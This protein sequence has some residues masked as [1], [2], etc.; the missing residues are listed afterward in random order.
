ML[1]N[2]VARRYAWPLVAVAQEH[3]LTEA[4]GRDLD[5]VLATLGADQRLS[6]IL[7]HPAV[8]AS[9]KKELLR[10]LFSGR[11]HPYA[12][13]FLFLLQD[14]KR[15][16]LLPVIVAE[17]H[18]EAN[19]ALGIL[20]VRVESARPLTPAQRDRLRS[21]LAKALQ[22]Q[23]SLEAQVRPELIGGLRIQVEDRVLDGS[24][25][26]QLE[27]LRQQITRTAPGA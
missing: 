8:Q 27:R 7:A 12:L 2:P 13:N 21:R 16:H 19:R 10:Q 18:R 15:G 26:Y 11:V 23:V 24:L 14:K 22:R 6:Q 20:T 17:Y 1:V 4:I 5:L 25:Q 9:Q 3:G